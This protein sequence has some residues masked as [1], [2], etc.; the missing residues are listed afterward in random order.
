MFK[1]YVIFI[2]KVEITKYDFVRSNDFVIYHDG[3]PFKNDKIKSFK[4]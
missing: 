4:I 2:R 1:N 3:I